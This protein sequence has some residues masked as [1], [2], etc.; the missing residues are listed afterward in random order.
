MSRKFGLS[1]AKD[2]EIE[3]HD[4]GVDI[5]Y[6]P[7]LMQGVTEKLADLKKV[8]ANKE[9][10]LSVTEAE[11]LLRFMEAPPAGMKT[12]ADVAKAY[13]ATHPDVKKAEN[14]LIQAKYELDMGQAAVDSVKSKGDS[15]K[16]EVTMFAL[17][18]FSDAGKGVKIPQRV[19]VSI[20]A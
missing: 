16:N 3:R 12:T 19:D 18:Y 17:G 6:Q 5:E 10:Q 4:L 9:L 1:L 8:K 2:L 11:T 14:E 7:S 15:I 13:V 20:D